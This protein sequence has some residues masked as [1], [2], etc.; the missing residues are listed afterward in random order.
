MFFF[1]FL[2]NIQL[3]HVHLFLPFNVS[4]DSDDELSLEFQSYL[5]DDVGLVESAL[6]ELTHEHQIDTKVCNTV[7]LGVV[8]YIFHF[9]YSLLVN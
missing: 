4:D 9:L 6:C 1:F 5:M 7:D 3:R 2:Q 8:C